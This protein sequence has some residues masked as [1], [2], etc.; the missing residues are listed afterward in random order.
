MA[1]T[2]AL[3]PYLFLHAFKGARCIPPWGRYLV[4]LREHPMGEEWLT[5]KGTGGQIGKP[6]PS[7]LAL[8]FIILPAT[9]TITVTTTVLN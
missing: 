4:N 9:P 8:F 2:S 5:F 3:L 7:A 1:V 6:S